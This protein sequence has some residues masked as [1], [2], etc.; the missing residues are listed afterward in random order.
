M[1]ARGGV[2][3]GGRWGAVGGVESEG[4]RCL[5]GGGEKGL[6]GRGDLGKSVGVSGVNGWFASL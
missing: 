2:E 5:G 4:G 6:K 3:V 1:M